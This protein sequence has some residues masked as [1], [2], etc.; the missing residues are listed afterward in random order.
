MEQVSVAILISFFSV[1]FSIFF[2]L[3][4]S[5]RTDIKDVEERVKTNTVLNVKLDNISNIT[6]DIKNELSSMKQDINAV[7]KRLTI[8]EQQA[9]SAHKRLDCVDEKLAGREMNH[10]E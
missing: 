1:A 4:N 3:K 5:K 7:D 10:Y 2:G 8:V 6:S 9:K